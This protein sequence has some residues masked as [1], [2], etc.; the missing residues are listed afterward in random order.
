LAQLFGDGGRI[1]QR[2]RA[3]ASVEG[4]QLGRDGCA[5]RPIVITQ[6]GPS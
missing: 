1:D 3:L 2:N 5:R 6:I 4:G